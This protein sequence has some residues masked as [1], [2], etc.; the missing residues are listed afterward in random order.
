MTK[1]LL[2]FSFLLS[3]LQL[4]YTNDDP[5]GERSDMILIKDRARTTS[6]INKG[7]G[8]FEVKDLIDTEFGEEYQIDY[9]FK[10]KVSFYGERGGTINLMV[11]KNYFGDSFWQQVRRGDIQTSN[12]KIKFKGIKERVAHNGEIYNNCPVIRIFDIQTSQANIL[13][14][15]IAIK[16][17]EMG[18]LNESDSFADDVEN[19]E[20]EGIIHPTLPALG[21]IKMNITGKV[22]NYD[23]KMGFDLKN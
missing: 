7:H 16:A 12:L 15:L 17:V 20:A 10:I 11:P 19:L 8:F 4:G 2:V 23:I 6:M 13:K 22:R 5:I 18:I 14:E 9:K 21:V 1:W 3:G